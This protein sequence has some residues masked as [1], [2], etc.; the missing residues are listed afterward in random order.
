MEAILDFA[1]NSNPTILL[2]LC[3]II[4]LLLVLGKEKMTS[5]IGN[6]F[7]KQS[8]TQYK[9]EGTKV[10][11]D[12]IARQLDVIAGNHLHELPEMNKN[13]TNIQKTVND[14][15]KKQNGDSERISKIEGYLKINI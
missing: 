1:K 11:L 10:S 4:I 3:L 2:C 5:T 12:T 14:I 15:Q 8:L 6:L 13:I 7:K 9:V